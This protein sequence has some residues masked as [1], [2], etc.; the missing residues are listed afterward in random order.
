[1]TQQTPPAFSLPQKSIEQAQRL[2]TYELFTP[3]AVFATP[4]GSGFVMAYIREQGYPPHETAREVEVIFGYKM[5]SCADSLLGVWK[6]YEAQPQAQANHEVKTMCIFCQTRAVLAS[7]QAQL[8]ALPD[9][10]S[11]LYDDKIADV[12]NAADEAHSLFRCYCG[13]QAAAAMMGDDAALD[14]V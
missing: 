10:G 4:D 8:E 1:M 9:V 14:S 13:E 6:K 7:I 12:I 11:A 2:Y 3:A 5:V